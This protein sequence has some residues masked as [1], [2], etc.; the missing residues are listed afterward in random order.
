MDFYQRSLMTGMKTRKNKQQIRA[1]IRKLSALFLCAGLLLSGLALPAAAEAAA[2]AVKP[3][4]W[5]AVDGLGR[6]VS[7][8][9]DVGDIREGKYVGMFY[10]TW[11]YD[12]AKSTSA[13]NIT[14]IISQYPEARN[15]YTHEAWGRNTGGKYFFWDKPMFDYYINTDEY[16]VRKHA[17]MLADA[18]V[19][20]IFFDC[21]NGTYLWQPAYETVFEVLHRRASRASIPRRL[22]SC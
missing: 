11:H 3:D 17:E 14:E 16:V 18:G 19:D 20:V 5:A 6:T 21:T 12:F 10:W 4:T 22:R 2:S 13:L 8:Y 9:Q 15:D 1:A 7:Q